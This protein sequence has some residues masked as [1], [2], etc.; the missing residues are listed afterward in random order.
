[1]DQ[2][3]SCDPIAALAEETGA[4]IVISGEILEDGRRVGVRVRITD[5]TRGCS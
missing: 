1:M 3:A 4:G 5:A 2:G